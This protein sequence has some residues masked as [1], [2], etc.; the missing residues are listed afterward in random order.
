MKQIVI[1]SNDELLEFIK[2]DEVTIS[3]GIKI[4]SKALNVLVLSDLT[5]EMLISQTEYY[6]KNY[7]NGD[8]QER[9]LFLENINLDTI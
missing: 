1:H 6:L 5:K 2:R 3:Q 7:C 8:K 9:P 4:I